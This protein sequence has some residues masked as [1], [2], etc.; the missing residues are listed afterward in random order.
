M[1]DILT[2]LVETCYLDEYILDQIELYY[3]TKIGKSGNAKQVRIEDDKEYS[4][5]KIRTI[6]D[7]DIPP[8]NL[9]INDLKIQVRN[10]IGDE[11]EVDCS[12][13]GEYMLSTM[14]RVDKII[15]VA[16][17]WI[18]MYQ[19]CYLIMDNAGGHGTTEVIT[20]YRNNLCTKYNVHIIFQVPHSTFTNVLD[21]GVWMTL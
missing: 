3:V 9:T 19:P 11:V 6:N 13:D 15:R 10:Q 1:E 14:E 4:S 21:L 8:Y 16:Y 7:T 12:F 17:H 20:T 5:Y 18:P 2:L